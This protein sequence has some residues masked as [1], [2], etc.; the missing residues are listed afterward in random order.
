M[1]T[2]DE[3][4]REYV[5]QW[6]DKA[7]MDLRA[8]EFLITASGFSD[9]ICFHAQQAVEKL[10][11]GCIR[12]LILRTVEFVS[13]RRYAVFLRA[14]EKVDFDSIYVGHAFQLVTETGIQ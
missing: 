14:I 1:K 2:P 4:T 9:V 3:V 7:D 8:A 5:R 11:K 10:L 12:D 13:I 6:L